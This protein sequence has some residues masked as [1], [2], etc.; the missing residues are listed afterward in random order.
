MISKYFDFIIYKIFILSMLSCLKINKL[1]LFERESFSL[2]IL[3]DL[4]KN[5][6]IAFLIY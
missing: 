4:N 3:E 2:F 5:F 1:L 6:V